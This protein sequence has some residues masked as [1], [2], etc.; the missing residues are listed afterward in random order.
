MSNN[1]TLTTH[2][3][4][5][6]PCHQFMRFYCLDV[7]L[8][9]FGVWTHLVMYELTTQKKCT[10]YEVRDYIFVGGE[11]LVKAWSNT[12]LQIKPSGNQLVVDCHGHIGGRL[13]NT[14]RVNVQ[15]FHLT[16]MKEKN[17]RI[18][19]IYILVEF[20]IE[21]NNQVFLL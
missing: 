21:L 8:C 1:K 19:V 4:Q 13:R 9:H 5:L 12:T 6:I 16:C 20:E 14:R 7:G 18:L 2:V 17:T 3:D 11:E 10:N 15:K